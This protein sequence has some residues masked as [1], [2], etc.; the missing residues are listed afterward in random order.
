MALNQADVLAGL[1]EIVE[2]VAGVPAASIEPCKI[3][4][5]HV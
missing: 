4:R 1:T 2:E 5:A 3:G